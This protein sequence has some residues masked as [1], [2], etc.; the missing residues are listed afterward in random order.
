MLYIFIHVLQ[1]IKYKIGLECT[2]RLRK[3][4]EVDETN[5]EY[6]RQIIIVSSA[7]A[8]KLTKQLAFKAGVDGFIEKPLQIQDVYNIY[9]D[10]VHRSE[11]ITSNSVVI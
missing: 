10:V 1:I 11:I 7:N 6:K 9:N 2:T 3:V 4:E 8:D 5:N